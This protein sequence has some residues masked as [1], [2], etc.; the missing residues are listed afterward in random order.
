[1]RVM[2]SAMML[3]LHKGDS[4]GSD[5][6]RSSVTVAGRVPG[7]R[8]NGP[9]HPSR[10]VVVYMDDLLCYSTTFEQHIQEVRKDLANL[11]H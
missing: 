4:P 7:A 1:M 5:D 11:R 6:D 8:G 2:S 9:L 10:S 3:G